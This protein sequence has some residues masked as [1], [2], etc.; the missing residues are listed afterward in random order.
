MHLVEAAGRRVLLDCG[1]FQGP[2]SEAHERN[3]RFPFPP[4]S[5]DAVVLSHAHIDHSGNL[6]NLVRQGFTGPIFCTP[7]TRDLAAVMLMDSGKI[8]EEDARYLN[9]H[10]APGDPETR[11][12]YERRDA[13]RTAGQMFGIPYRRAFDVV[14]GI[15]GEFHDAG[16]ILGS[17]MVALSIN[18]RPSITF[19][20][21]L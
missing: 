4:S 17:A 9:R 5:I 2:R 12:L 11:P 15:R 1:M 7:A 16:H 20:G 14:P 3:T 8:Q 13:H 10:R 19:T 6:P 21:D 18:G